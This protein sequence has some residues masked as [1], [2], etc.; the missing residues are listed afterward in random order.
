MIT[1]HPYPCAREAILPFFDRVSQSRR[2]GPDASIADLFVYLH[3]TLLTKV[4]LDDFGAAFDRYKEKLQATLLNSQ[5]LS[6]TSWMMM[7]MTNI[8]ALLKYATKDESLNKQHKRRFDKAP[9]AKPTEGSSSGG[10]DGSDSDEGSCSD[11]DGENI[12]RK[13]GGFAPSESEVDIG[14]EEQTLP[15]AERCALQLAFETLDIS[16]LNLSQLPS[17]TCASYVTTMM[18]FLAHEARQQETLRRFESFIPWKSISRLGNSTFLQNAAFWPPN[19]TV[20]FRIRNESGPLP[21]DW[22]SRGTAWV[23]RQVYERGFWK[24]A[25]GFE[26]SSRIQLEG[27]LSPCESEVDVFKQYGSLTPAVSEHTASDHEAIYGVG[28]SPSEPHTAPFN[29][30]ALA[31]ARWKRIAHTLSALANFVP[32]LDR[33]SDESG[34]VRYVLVSPLTEKMR[35]WHMIQK[36][37]HVLRELQTIQISAQSN[38]EQPQGERN[39][40]AVPDANADMPDQKESFA[41]DREDVRLLKERRQGLQRQLQE[42][43]AAQMMMRHGFGGTGAV[44]GHDGKSTGVALGSSKVSKGPEHVH[45][46]PGYTVLVMDTNVIVAPTHAF[47]RLVESSQWT[48]VVPLSVVTELDG[49]ARRAGDV[50]DRAK[51]ALHYMEVNNKTKSVNLK[52]QTSRGN[53]LAD[54]RLRS[55]KID[56]DGREGGDGSA[57]STGDANDSPEAAA[58]VPARHTQGVAKVPGRLISAGIDDHYHDSDAG[59]PASKVKASS[60]RSVDDVILRCLSWQAGNYWRDRLLMLCPDDSERAAREA[61]I[62]SAASVGNDVTHTSGGDIDSRNKS[63][64]KGSRTGRDNESELRPTARAVLVTLDRNLRLKARAQGL[65]SIGPDGVLEAGRE[66]ASVQ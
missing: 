27:T 49:L 50:G 33:E 30:E 20:A 45:V 66:W 52:V 41:E 14:S 54:L 36:Q 17:S 59:Q 32:G 12:I 64:S 35:T 44:Y 48:I 65:Q 62:M 38:R 5:P 11:S 22:C 55:E 60:A 7:A 42:M 57:A 40:Q 2:A 25:H 9:P 43:S 3:G 23:G 29:L 56:F 13:N 26:P 21:E 16:L 28:Q 18:T 6:Q 37:E 61:H 63:K 24:Q 15:C 34:R 39:L 31:L 8:A 1:S 4:Q 19:D 10:G 46:M 58:E 51:R 53:Y 47:V